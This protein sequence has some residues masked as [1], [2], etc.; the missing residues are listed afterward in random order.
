MKRK[1]YNQTADKADLRND[2]DR[3]IESF[4]AGG[5]QIVNVQAGETALESRAA[6]LRTP[7]FNEP[8][9]SRTPLDD[10]V[11]TLDERRKTQLKS[12]AKPKRP[13]K[14]QPRKRVIY[15]DFGEAVRTVWSDE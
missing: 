2:L 15:D 13:R 12:A 14:T 11:A 10:V 9:I 8:R 6:P 1:F 7:I 3:D 5:G 4:L